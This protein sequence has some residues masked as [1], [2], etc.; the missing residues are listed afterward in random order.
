M[1]K[2]NKV[3]L[4]KRYDELLDELNELKEGDQMGKEL[5]IK[6]DDQA[7]DPNYFENT[8]KK[9]KDQIAHMQKRNDQEKHSSMYS[10]QEI[11]MV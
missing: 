7:M 4:K 2:E 10:L 5:V 1:A 9:F 3:N 11:M 6:K 8:V